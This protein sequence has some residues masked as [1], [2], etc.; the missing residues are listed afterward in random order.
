MGVKGGEG[1]IRQGGET[2]R[3]EETYIIYDKRYKTRTNRVSGVK[4]Q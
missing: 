3:G 2:G 4:G 1:E